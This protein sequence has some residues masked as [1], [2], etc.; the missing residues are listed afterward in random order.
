MNEAPWHT[1]FIGLVCF[2][3][4]YAMVA[5]LAT[6]QAP[7]P[8]WV[9]AAPL[10]TLPQ[11][12]FENSEEYWRR[13]SGPLRRELA[14]SG[15]TLGESRLRQIVDAFH[16]DLVKSRPVGVLAIPPHDRQI[17]TL[18]QILGRAGLGLPGPQLDKIA[19]GSLPKPIFLTP[20]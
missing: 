12:A 10:P 2:L 5:S 3:V 4:F 19:H 11:V 20:F 15:K 7:K 6:R 17:A 13:L 9:P 1:F 8:N 16:A 18:R 14:K